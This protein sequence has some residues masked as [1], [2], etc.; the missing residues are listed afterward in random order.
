MF[1][2]L[3]RMQTR[4][5]LSLLLSCSL[6]ALLLSQARHEATDIAVVAN[7]S[8]PGDNLS[9]Y[10]VR[11]VFKGEKQY[12]KSDLPVV[13]VVPA[14][15]THER[16]VMLQLIY[17]MTESEYRQYWIGRIFRADATSPP[18][19]ADSSEIA[20]D[21][22]ASLPGC[23]TVISSSDVTPGKKIK[24]FKVDGKLPGEKGYPLR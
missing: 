19:T 3:V 10:E 2:T 13:L 12:W 9:I 21:L 17:K 20:K 22:V 18:K 14:T 24:I 16:D 5:L 7:A 6:P 11:H 15:G 23:V 8:V 4:P 1:L